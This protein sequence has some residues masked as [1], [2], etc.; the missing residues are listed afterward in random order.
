M[1]ELNL[2]VV[3]ALVLVVARALVLMMVAR[4]LVLLTLF[5]VKGVTPTNAKTTA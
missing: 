2:L 3:R 1:K 4:A 5:P